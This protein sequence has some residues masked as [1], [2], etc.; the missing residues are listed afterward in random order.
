MMPAAH[1][2]LVRPARLAADAEV[3]ELQR[4]TY[5]TAGVTIFLIGAALIGSA[6][7]TV[8]T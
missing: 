7:F 8:S 3:E 2:L 6:G 1:R 5:P 4:L